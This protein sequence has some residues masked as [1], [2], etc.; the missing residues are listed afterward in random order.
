M[1]YLCNTHCIAI[2]TTVFV[3]CVQF[4]VSMVGVVVLTCVAALIQPPSHL[5]DL[6]AVV[7]STYS[8]FHFLGFFVVFHWLQWTAVDDRQISKVA[9]V[10]S[11]K[12][13]TH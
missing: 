9:S 3:C 6:H 8:F 5:P 7:I 10:D 13:K 1:L 11:R 4:W 12:L 2:C